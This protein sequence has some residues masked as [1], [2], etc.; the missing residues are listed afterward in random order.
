[1]LSRTSLLFF[2]GLDNWFDQDVL[3]ECV[4]KFS[5]SSLFLRT[6]CMCSHPRDDVE[7]MAHQLDPTDLL[8]V[9]SVLN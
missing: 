5:F 4:S 2:Q 8:N 1:M 6:V 9:D 3:S 7:H